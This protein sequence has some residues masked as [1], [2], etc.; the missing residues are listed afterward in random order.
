MNLHRAGG[1]VGSVSRA[2]QGAETGGA[3]SWASAGGL[4]EQGAVEEVG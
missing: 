1:R 2:V 3:G 4:R